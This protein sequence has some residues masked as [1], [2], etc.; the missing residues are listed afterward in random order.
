MQN[1][2]LNRFIIF[3]VTIRFYGTGAEGSSDLL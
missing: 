1:N 3:F 2:A